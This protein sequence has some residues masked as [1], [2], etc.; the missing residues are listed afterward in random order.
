MLNRA[1]LANLIIFLERVP[2]TGKE[3][4]AWSET[5]S[6]VAEQIRQIDAMMAKAKESPAKEDAE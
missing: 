3:A 4:F 2:V 6:A 1:T 5:Y